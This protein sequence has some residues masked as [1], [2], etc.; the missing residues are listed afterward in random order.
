MIVHMDFNED[1]NIGELHYLLEVTQNSIA[2][3]PMGFPNHE[4]MTGFE[5]TMNTIDTNIRQDLAGMNVGRFIYQCQ[6]KDYFYL[7][8]TVGVASILNSLQKNHLTVNHFRYKLKEDKDH[9]VY[10]E[11]I[12]PD[13]YLLQTMVN[14]KIIQMLER[15]KFDFNNKASLKHTASFASDEDRTKYRRFIQEQNFRVLELDKAEA[16]PLPYIIQFSR[17]D[18]LQLEALSNITLRLHQKATFLNGSYEGWEIELE[19]Q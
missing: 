8:D 1:R 6:V 15:E 16:N 19:E 9:K 7:E 18:K 12:Y 14:G 3:D 10:S 4:E 13:D 2:C 5:S 17:N 11:L